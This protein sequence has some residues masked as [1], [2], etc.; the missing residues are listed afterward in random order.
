MIN[1][2]KQIT[3]YNEMFRLIDTINP[4][5]KR[6]KFLGKLFDYYFKDKKPKLKPNSL[7]E[8]I[9]DNISKPLKSYKSKVDNGSKGGRPKKTESKSEIKSENKSES[10]TT[11][12]VSNYDSNYVVNVNVNVN[13]IVDYLEKNNIILSS[14]Q[15]E[16]MYGWLEDF[17]E[18]EIIEAFNVM[19]E[20]HKGFNYVRGIVRN[21]RNGDKKKASVPQ[22]F[23]QDLKAEVLSADEQKEL[24]DMLKKYKED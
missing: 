2:I 18:D 14:T 8:I 15:F 1:K 7:E 12:V 3:I 23:N 20:Q 10:K 13:N 16:E 22:W 19:I 4:Q 5:E 11:T 24:E 17:T 21:W 9:W 6:D